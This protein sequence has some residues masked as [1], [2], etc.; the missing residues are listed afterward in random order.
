MNRGSNPVSLATTGATDVL[1][2]RSL[3]DRWRDFRNTLVSDRRFQAAV[4]RLPVLRSIGERNTRRIFDQCAGFVYSQ[5]LLACV[6]LGVLAVLARD[7][8]TGGELANR[9]GLRPDAAERLL[10]AAAALGLVEDRSAGRYGLGPAGAVIAA[11]P[12]LLAMISHHRI[13]YADLMDPAAMLRGSG[14]GQQMPAYWAYAGAKRPEGLNADQITSYSALMTASQASLA[15]DVLDAYRFD[16]HERLMDIGGGDG[17]FVEAAAQRLPGLQFICFDLPPVAQRATRRF[18]SAG[19]SGRA[20][21]CGGNFLTDPLPD[22]AD[23]VT[24]LRVVLDHDDDTVATLLRAVRQALRPQGVLVIAE[25]I[26][27]TPG[28]ERI[29]DTYF[30]IYLMAMGN[31]KTRTFKELC[32]LLNAAGF[33]RTRR[34]ATRNRLLCGLVVARA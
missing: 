8:P 30:G 18:E 5:T 13:L 28:A 29:T 23:I 32:A 4:M 12:G 22:G 34:I 2:K 24:L 11:D 27:G 3:T 7:T 17:G 16:R 33:S 15:A 21:A 26:S 1:E 6:E 19:L 25:P 9:L 14:H 20:V 10:R 31:G